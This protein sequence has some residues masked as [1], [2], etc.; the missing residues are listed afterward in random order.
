MNVY[1]FLIPIN[2]I[3][4]QAWATTV[5]TPVLHILQGMPGHFPHEY[6]ME[7]Q[8]ELQES[9]FPT[10]HPSSAAAMQ[11]VPCWCSFDASTQK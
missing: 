8:P 3:L 11:K 2:S 1:I 7:W 4:S 10:A 9:A 5:Q 6:D